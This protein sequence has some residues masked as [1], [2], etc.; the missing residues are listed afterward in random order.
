[1]NDLGN[2]SLDDQMAS[3]GLVR[4]GDWWVCQKCGCKISRSGEPINC[5]NCER[6]KNRDRMERGKYKH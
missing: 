1:M 6:K 3:T 4:K 2:M 5:P